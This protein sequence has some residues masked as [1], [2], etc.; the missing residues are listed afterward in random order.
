MIGSRNDNCAFASFETSSNGRSISWTKVRRMIM[1]SASRLRASTRTPLRPRANW[2]FS[3]GK[4]LICEMKNS[5]RTRCLHLSRRCCRQGPKRGF[6]LTRL[7]AHM[8]WAAL[9]FPGVEDLVE[10]ETRV[11]YILPK[12][13]DP[14]ICTY[15]LARFDSRVAFDILRTH[16]LVIIGGVLHENP[17]FVPPDQFLLELRE[18]KYSRRAER[19]N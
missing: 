15:D 5:T 17:F 19:T 4:T 6:P 8:E 7:V 9:D 2:R 1:S 18:R 14:V 13:D 16:P 3:A 12:Y 10:Y 11:N